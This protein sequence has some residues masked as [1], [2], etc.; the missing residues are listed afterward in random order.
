MII[1]A[2]GSGKTWLARRLAQ[3]LQL[4]VYSVDDAVWDENGK[5]READEIDRLV[6][7]VVFKDC[8]VIEGGNSRTYQDRANRAELVIRMAPPWWLRVFRILM[9]DGIRLN[10]VRTTIQYDAIF[11]DKDSAA[12]AGASKSANTIEIRNRRDAAR[13]IE[14]YKNQK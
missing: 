11:G 6:R 3:Q 5:L 7:A 8:W 2:P 13:V 1:G 9:R 14:Y 10:L 4:P 12:L